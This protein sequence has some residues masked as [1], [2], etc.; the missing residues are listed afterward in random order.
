MGEEFQYSKKR[1]LFGQHPS[2]E[3]VDTRIVGKM[4]PRLEAYENDYV[5]RN[6]NKVVLDNIPQFSEHRVSYSFPQIRCL[7][8][9]EG[10]WSAIFKSLRL[11]R[12]NSNFVTSSFLCLAGEH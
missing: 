7:K 3:D 8:N 2:F 5:Q 9:V 1:H 11:S 12:M 4:D 6:P 10:K